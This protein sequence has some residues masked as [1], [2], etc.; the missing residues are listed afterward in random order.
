LQVW[1]ERY[2][3][4]LADF[5][6]LQDQIAQSV[7]AAIEPRLYAAEHQRFQSRSLDSLD[8]WGFVMKA[9]P[10]VWDWGLRR[11]SRSPRLF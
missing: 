6:N 10:Y 11:R 5:F 1:A 2:D 3:V 4:D 9:M 8:A 7:I